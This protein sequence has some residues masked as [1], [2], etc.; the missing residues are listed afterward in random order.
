[1]TDSRM[2]TP[3]RLNRSKSKSKLLYDWLF[4]ANQN[5][6]SSSPLRPTTRNFFP[7]LN[8]CGISPYVTSSLMRRWVCLLWICLA[9]RQVLNRSSLPGSLYTLPVTMENVSFHGNVLTK[10]LASN[11]LVRCCGNV[12]LASRWLA[13]DFRSSSSIPDFGRHVTIWN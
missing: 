7:Q 10:P 9:F 3:L 8:P 1:M 4:T 2:T 6:L 5:V 13:M 12:C 11:A